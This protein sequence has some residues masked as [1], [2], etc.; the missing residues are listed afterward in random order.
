MTDELLLTHRHEETQ[1]PMHDVRDGR[2]DG[3]R[4]REYACG[5]GFGAAVL[6]RA[7]DEEPGARWPNQFKSVLPLA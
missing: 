1:E 3:L 7:E 2:I 6:S 4:V 5:C